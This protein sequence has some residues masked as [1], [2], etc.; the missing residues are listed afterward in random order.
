MSHQHNVIAAPLSVEFRPTAAKWKLRASV[1]D[2]GLAV[3]DGKPH[4]GKTGKAKDAWRIREEFLAIHDCAHLREFLDQTGYFHLSLDVFSRLTEWQGLISKLMVTPPE[5]W[6]R[7]KETLN[8]KQRLAFSKEAPSVLFRWKDEKP[9][10]AIW[11]AF[12]LNAMVASIQVDHLRGA[13]FAFCQRTDCGNIYSI[14]S[15][16]RRMYCSYE[17]GHLVAVRRARAA[18]TM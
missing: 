14:E 5:K 11:A 4:F 8:W 18:K 13:K 16:H 9:S 10:L 3:F 7:L 6:A 2:A 1:E 15:S 17:C 12:T